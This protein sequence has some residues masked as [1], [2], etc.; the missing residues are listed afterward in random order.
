MRSRT[1]R[2]LVL[3]VVVVV[4]VLL[5]VPVSR[6]AKRLA[7]PETPEQ[8]VQRG[9]ALNKQQRYDAAVRAFSEAIRVRTDMADAYLYR[10]MALYAAG[11]MEASVADFN[12]V[13]KLR[14]G[15]AVVYLYRG[16]SYFAMGQKAQAIADYQQA[17]ALADGDEQLTVAA[18]TKLYMIQESER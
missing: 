16:D 6:L 7:T 18:H 14:P 17:L 5:A 13:L 2:N 15:S 4:L 8:S 12:Q 10:G 3:G 9:L 11:Q 1:R